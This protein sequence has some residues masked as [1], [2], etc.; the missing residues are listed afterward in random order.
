MTTF[1]NL[2]RLS[3]LEKAKRVLKSLANGHDYRY[4]YNDGFP[5]QE[6][7]MRDAAATLEVLEDLE[8]RSNER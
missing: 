8:R 2:S 4:F 3:R 7:I 6:D 1:T 5:R